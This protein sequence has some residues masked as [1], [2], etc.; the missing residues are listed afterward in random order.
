MR[1]LEEPVEMNIL[2]SYSNG[3]DDWIMSTGS[4]PPGV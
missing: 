1:Y 3:P 4:E 2:Y